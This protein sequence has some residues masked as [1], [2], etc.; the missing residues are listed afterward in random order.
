MKNAYFEVQVDF[1]QIE[2]CVTNYIE[3][4]CACLT[5]GI[6]DG[7]IPTFAHWKEDRVISGVTTVV[8]SHWRGNRRLNQGT[9]ADGM[10]SQ[11]WPFWIV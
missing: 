8:S 11:Q 10:D 6:E 3:S 7:I 1:K 2:I 4:T 5:D 9:A